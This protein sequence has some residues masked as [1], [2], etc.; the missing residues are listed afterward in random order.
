MKPESLLMRC[1]PAEEPD[2]DV[3]VMASDVDIGMM[4]HP[5]FPVPHIG[6]GANQIQRHRHH[7]VDPDVVG[8][9]QMPPVMSNIE[10]HRTPSYSHH[11]AN[12]QTHRPDSRH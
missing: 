9:L 3:C 12:R 7:P 2:I 10:T 11:N 4:D 1:Q 5:M 8:L 6:T